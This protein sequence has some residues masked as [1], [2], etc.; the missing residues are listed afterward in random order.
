MRGP[1]F[2][3]EPQPWSPEE[4]ASPDPVDMGAFGSIYVPD[5][6]SLDDAQHSPPNY[7]PVINGH[8]NGV[9]HVSLFLLLHCVRIG[10]VLLVRRKDATRRVSTALG[11]PLEGIQ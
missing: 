4:F 7:I 6:P 2:S 9:Q 8:L 1:A 10:A 11:G 3:N 5:E